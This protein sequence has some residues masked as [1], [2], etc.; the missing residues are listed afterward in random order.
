MANFVCD[1]ILAEIKKLDPNVDVFALN[2]S[3]FR[4]GFDLEGEK[5]VSNFDILSS[6]GGIN[7]KQANIFTTDVTGEEL[8]FLVKDNI[9]YNSFNPER[10]PLF[11]YSGLK[12]DKDLILADLSM[13]IRNYCKYITIGPQ[14]EPLD[15]DKIYRIANPEKYFIK[16]KV[17]EIKALFERSK[18]LN[19][20][21]IELF[22]KH[23]EELGCVTFTPDKR[24]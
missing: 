9:A 19:C 15:A 18:P 14:N 24:I 2:A 23:F 5:N 16:T 4:S 13:P 22:K 10:R 6:L 1:S 12:T 3:T 8:A 17:P 21:V 20:N 7:Q 11:H